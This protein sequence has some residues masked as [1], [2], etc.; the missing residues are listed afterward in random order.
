MSPLKK[1]VRDLPKAESYQEW[2]DLAD[3]IDRCNGGQEWRDDPRSDL[4]HSEL[5]Q[6]HL[7]EIRAARAALNTERLMSLVTESLYRHLGEIS[8]PRLYQVALTGT[9]TIISD[10][11]N[12]VCLA[13]EQLGDTHIPELSPEARLLKFEQAFH[14][15]G[16]SA[17]IL[18]GGAAF[19]IYHLG[20]AKALWEQ[21]LLPRAISGSSMGSIVAA[22]LCT[23]A[24]DEL[25][26]FFR[27]L[28]KVHRKA[29]QRSTLRD[30]VKTGFLMD[31]S[32][33]LEHIRHNVGDFSFAE[34]F[35]H[36]GRILN[37]T[38]SPTRTH[39]KPRVLSHL[40]SPNVSISHSA[41]ASCAIPGIFPPVQLRAKSANGDSIPYME[42]EE[43]I[44]GS[45]H[46]DVPLLRIGRLHNVNHTIVSQ[47]NPHVLPFITHKNKR[48]L[49]PFTKHVL[50][51]IV[52]AQ[53]TEV[54]EISRDLM[55]NS[56]WRP[57]VDK[58]YGMARQSYLGD[59]NIHL[60]FSLPLY[61]KVASN[62]NQEEFEAYIRFGEKAT[63]PKIAEIR[64]QTRIGTTLENTIAKLRGEV[65]RR[66]LAKSE[67]RKESK[68][69]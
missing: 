7:D 6:T 69:A 46:S 58:A 59:I 10:Y 22:G 48:G 23:R 20:V 8:N 39:Q 28:D 41:L 68:L 4:F 63:W 17:L 13:I 65:A 2:L 36:S 31:T 21:R 16:R 1:L 38:V 47:A 9:K 30:L 50:S 45:V 43:W 49:V 27:Q 42:T 3:Q 33:L 67:S 14:N 34:A 19:G 60:P 52:H 5:L 15:Y 29:L 51:S 62:P 56:S 53:I 40:T 66:A 44:D 35:A 11:L 64:D 18:S 55:Q 25:D 12:E 37:I 57:L 54:L 24:D 61:K 26:L 32:A